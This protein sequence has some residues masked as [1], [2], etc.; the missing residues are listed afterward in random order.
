[1]QKTYLYSFL[2]IFIFF[3]L[4]CEKKDEVNPSSET[5]CTINKA[6]FFYKKGEDKNAYTLY[7][8]YE[9]KLIKG[10]THYD[11]NNNQ[12]GYSQNTLDNQGRYSLREY[13]DGSGQIV[14]KAEYSYP[15]DKTLLYKLYKKKRNSSE[16]Y[17]NSER[18]YFY[19]NQNNL[20]TALNFLKKPKILHTKQILTSY[21]E[22]SSIRYTTIYWA[23]G[24]FTVKK[25][26]HTNINNNNEETSTT[27]YIRNKEDFLEKEEFYINDELQ[28]YILYTGTG[29]TNEFEVKGYQVDGTLTGYTGIHRYNQ[30][31]ALLYLLVK[32]AN[33]GTYEK[34]YQKEYN[35]YGYRVLYSEEI[36]RRDTNGV[37]QGNIRYFKKVYEEISCD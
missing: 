2:T 26:R 34:T 6:S 24:G 5:I 11:I 7:T 21:N 31:K 36:I 18:E 3:L 4:G 9:N 19:S 22:D 35:E 16:L 28:S 30:E 15:N 8:Y 13:F 25:E 1:M 14:S 29:Q 10:S 12:T 23:E 27:L 17:L 33:G 20:R 37:L 32:Y